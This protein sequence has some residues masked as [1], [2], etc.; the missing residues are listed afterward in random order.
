MPDKLSTTNY[1]ESVN[2]LIE[3]LKNGGSEQNIS[4]RSNSKIL[5][6]DINDTIGSSMSKLHR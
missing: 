6:D 4:Q 2:L 1:K 3:G 5:L